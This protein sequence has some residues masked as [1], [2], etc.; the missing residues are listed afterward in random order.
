M[1]RKFRASEHGVSAVEFALVSPLVVTLIM[2]ILEFG[3][4]F[5]TMMSAEFATGDA[6]RRLAAHNITSS[7]VSALVVAG[8][9]QWAQAQA[10]AAATQ[11]GA[12]PVVWTITTTIPMA[13]ATPTNFLASVYGSSNLTVKSVMQQEPTY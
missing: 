1:L 5:Y 6:S 8:L 13:T 7:Q 10:S 12:S 2:G 9:P 3:C 11:S 4:I